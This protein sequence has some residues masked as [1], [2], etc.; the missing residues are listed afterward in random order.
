MFFFDILFYSFSTTPDNQLVKKPFSERDDVI[1]KAL[2]RSVKRFYLQE[3]RND[4]PAITKKRYKHSNAF[5]IFD[6]FKSTCLRLFGDIPNL[7]KITQFIMI[8]SSFKS[9]NTYPFDDKI[10]AKVE[11]VNTAMYKYS[12]TK[13]QKVFRIKEFEFVFRHIF[14]N[15]RDRI[16]KLWNKKEI[17]NKEIYN[18]MLDIWLAKFAV[19]RVFSNY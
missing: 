19:G 1:N 2:L 15:H 16:F 5:I 12:Y 17:Q 13:L 7:N 9:T 18:K 14:E 11:Q 8:L 4:N 10:V 3:F 6:G